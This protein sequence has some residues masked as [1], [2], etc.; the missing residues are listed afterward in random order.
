MIFRAHSKLS[1][2]KTPM[3]E[4]FLQTSKL[5][6]VE[7]LFQKPLIRLFDVLKIKSGGHILQFYF[8]FF[9]KEYQH[10]G[11]LF[12]G[13]FHEQGIRSEVC[14]SENSSFVTRLAIISFISS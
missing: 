9:R 10:K 1:Q 3:P 14:K 2:L 6:L 13:G 5:L 12:A 8:I 7:V 11:R 4:Q